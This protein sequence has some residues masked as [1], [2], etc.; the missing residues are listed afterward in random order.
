MI[1]SIIGG[2]IGQAGANQAAGTAQGAAQQAYL[3]NQAQAQANRSDASPWTN[4][5]R[6]A[7]SRIGQLLGWGTLEN[8]GKPGTLYEFTG[9]NS[10]QGIA[11]ADMKNFI[12]T[13]YGEGA[14]DPAKG[15][16]ATVATPTLDLLNVPTKFGDDPGYK[17]RLEEG[18]KALDRSAAAKGMLLS[19]A[20]IQ[21]TN[22]YNQGMASQEYGNWWNR[23]TS[24]TAANNATK[25]QDYS[26]KNT[27][28]GQDWTKFT[29]GREKA[30]AYVNNY[31]NMLSGMSGQGANSTTALAGTNS[32]LVNSGANYLASAGQ[33]AGNA[34]MAGANALA[35][36]IGNG[37]NNL[38][39]GAWMGF[40]P[41]SGIFTGG[42]GGSSSLTP[43]G[44]AVGRGAW[45]VR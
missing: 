18:Q 35:S 4:A 28:F 29:Y 20:Q 42:G 23:Y 45:P 44:Q 27:A 32:G 19:G 36:G 31:L 41:T 15:A 22:D 24:A 43:A 7:I 30:D 21:A 3:A 2:M 11:V 40:N 10:N 16:P 9:D 6:N 38:M 34:Q 26:N 8:P 5:G 12:R 1:G 25:Q 39:T 33:Y 17:F 14:L 13:M 37:F